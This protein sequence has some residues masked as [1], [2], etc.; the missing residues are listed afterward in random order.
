MI[1]I[2]YKELN[3]KEVGLYMTSPFNNFKVRIC[4]IP[5][6]AAISVHRFRA[7]RFL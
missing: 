1:S 7:R 6:V 2:P 4:L 3:A 5:A